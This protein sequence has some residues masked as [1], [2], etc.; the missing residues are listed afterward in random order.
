MSNPLTFRRWLGTLAV[1]FVPFLLA[2]ILSPLVGSEH[3]DVTEAFRQMWS[4]RADAAA[5]ILFFQRVPR[6]I[7]GLL[8]GGAALNGFT[9]TNGHTRTD[10]M[11]WEDGV[12]GGVYCE[13]DVAVSDCVRAQKAHPSPHSPV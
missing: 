12:G 9:V 3:V 7:L 1:Y 8:A 6:V 4:G 5:H 10:D 2:L 13:D 11:S